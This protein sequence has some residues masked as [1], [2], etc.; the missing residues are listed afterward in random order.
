MAVIPAVGLAEWLLLDRPERPE[1]R[2]ALAISGALAA[3]F[4]ALA[5]AITAPAILDRQENLYD[6]LGFSFSQHLWSSLATQI[7]YALI[8]LVPDHRL[9]TIDGEVEIVSSLAR[10]TSALG[11]A[12]AIALSIVLALR[13]RKRYPLVTFGI[14]WY[15][16][17]Q[18]V[19]VA[20][21]PQDLYFEHRLY[22][23]S[24]FLFLG[25]ASL[26]LR[27]LQARRLR[28]V[29]VAFPI[30]FL[31]AEAY[32]TSQ[33]NHTWSH[34]VL[35]WADAAAKAPTKAR[36][37]LN[38]ANAL[39][40]IGQYDAAREMFERVLE[41]GGYERL[42]LYNLGI[43]AY[44]DGDRKKARNLMNRVVE[45]GGDMEWKARRFLAFEALEVGDIERAENHIKHAMSQKPTDA[46]LW[47]LMGRIYL[48]RGLY[49][50]A[51][52]SFRTALRYDP[53]FSEAEEN[54]R[55]I[56]ENAR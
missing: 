14:G 47:N 24:V 39:M 45:L 15:L 16:A 2:R 1:T 11:G 35:L 27:C 53:L 18:S 5:V 54:L 37:H 32:S 21:L 9:L 43:L 17:T 22:V 8:L 23:P 44:R 10:S 56:P 6:T 55:K 13:L 36:P 3:G 51:E 40:N 49:D 7:R 25:V 42:T 34:P 38:L 12:S 4:C 50:E 26:A 46:G 33:R 29:A 31:A 30:L 28:W 52:S 20:L 41:L 48:H 19:E